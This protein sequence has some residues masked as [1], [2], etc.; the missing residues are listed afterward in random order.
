M[1]DIRAI[2]EN[3]AAFDAALA[4]RG[5]APVSSEILELDSQ[6]RSGDSAYSLIR[7]IDVLI[8]LMGEAHLIRAAQSPDTLS[9][10]A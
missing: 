10:F 9:D 4:R 6:R 2:R 3:P 8:A 7:H 5:D 1:H